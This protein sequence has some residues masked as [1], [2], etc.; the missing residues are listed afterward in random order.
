MTDGSGRISI[1]LCGRLADF[2]GDVLTLDWPAGALSVADLRALVGAASPELEAEWAR[3]RIR[4]C[5]DDA[6]VGE[7]APLHAGQAVALFPPV[8]GG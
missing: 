5:V 4:I 2:G 6:I 7:D 1:T 8:S 3:G